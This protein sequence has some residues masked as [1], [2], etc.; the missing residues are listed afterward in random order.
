M[1]RVAEEQQDVAM[2][3]V[4]DRHRRLPR[5]EI[6]KVVV[7]ARALVGEEGAIANDMGET[8]GQMPTEAKG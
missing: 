8:A 6:N 4:D 1:P 7:D 5:G 3:K 2:H